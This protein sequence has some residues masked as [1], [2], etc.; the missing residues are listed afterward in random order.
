M[1][2]GHAEY[3]QAEGMWEMACA[4]WT[5]WLSP[6]VGPK[7]LSIPGGKA[8]SYLQGPRDIEKSLNE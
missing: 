7:T 4:G 1:A 8:H 2:L 5:F 3:S 6:E